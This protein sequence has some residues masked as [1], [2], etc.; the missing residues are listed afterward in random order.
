MLRQFKMEF[1]H[2]PCPM[3]GIEKVAVPMYIDEDS[4][5]LGNVTNL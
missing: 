5:I 3:R 2:E 4:D 1:S